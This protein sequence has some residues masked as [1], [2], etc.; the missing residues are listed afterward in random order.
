M[1]FLKHAWYTV[2]WSSGLGVTP[3]ART[4]TD[5]YIVLYRRANGTRVALDNAEAPVINVDNAPLQAR[6][7]VDQLIAAEHNKSPDR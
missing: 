2:V 3:V 5:E 4:I 7:I 6:R 1:T